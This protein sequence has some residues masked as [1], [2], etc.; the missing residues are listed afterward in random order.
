[1]TPPLPRRIGH[2]PIPL[3]LTYKTVSGSFPFR[4]T[5]LI[6]LFFLSG[7]VRGFESIV[8]TLKQFSSPTRFSRD[9]SFTEQSFL[10]SP[11][12]LNPGSPFLSW[13]MFRK[14]PP[15]PMRKFFLVFSPSPQVRYREWRPI[16]ALRNNDSAVVFTF[17]SRD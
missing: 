9:I 5:S 3:N 12:S 14:P 13:S 4:R 11:P 10:T 17:F 8:L 15:L 1:V 7:M 2:R 6:F 16:A